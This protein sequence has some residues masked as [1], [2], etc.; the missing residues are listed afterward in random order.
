[1]PFAL[2]DRVSE[3]LQA[4]RR[5]A[6]VAVA[7]V[8]TAALTACGGGDQVKKFQPSKIV[9]F[10][11]ESSTLVTEDVLDDQ[12][13]VKGQLKGLKYT[14]NA[15]QIFI[16]RD[17]DMNALVPAI[18]SGAV[19]SPSQAAW[20]TFPDLSAVVTGSLLVHNTDQI[21]V[22]FTL[23]VAYTDSG[24]VARTDPLAVT[25]QYAYLCGA[26]RLWIQ[27]LANGYGLGYKSQCAVD[28]DGAV[29]YA[30]AGARVST[31]VG[32]VL[33]IKSQVAAHRSE[34]DSNTLVTVLAGQNDILEEYAASVATTS[35]HENAKARMVARGK[36]L[37]AIVNDIT[38]TGARVLIVTVPDLGLSPYAR[39]TNGREFMS[40]LT[41]SFN[42][43]FIGAGG[44]VNNGNKI[45]L[46]KFYDDSRNIADYLS[47]YGF[48]NIST[49]LCTGP[50]RKPDGTAVTAATAPFFGGEELRY[51]TSANVTEDIGK[52]FWADEVN[53][54]PGA[55]A[56]LGSLAYQRAD[57]NPF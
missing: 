8:M 51:C 48:S 45:G 7:L 34:L 4:R 40:A 55:H 22:Q 56:R 25:Y 28:L 18:P 39:N 50:F 3:T 20:V 23:P 16:N 32:G 21:E 11:D 2:V 19:L 41:K 52:Y 13:A 36:E 57:D 53:L 26:N 38:N 43:G 30:Q 29:S 24:S 12:S 49:P 42:D 47:S 17:K 6:G 46:V 35:D 9:S 31:D 54:S 44:V 5:L 37:A 15:Q 10:G 27:L 14:V 33:S 1:M